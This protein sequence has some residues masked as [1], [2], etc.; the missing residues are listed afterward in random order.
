MSSN[1]TFGV[2]YEFINSISYKS[3]D[4]KIQTSCTPWAI[5]TAVLEFMLANCHTTPRNKNHQLFT[6]PASQPA[7]EPTHLHTRRI[8]E[9]ICFTCQT[10]KKPKITTTPT[11]TMSGTKQTTCLS[12]CPSLGCKRFKQQCHDH[13][14]SYPLAWYACPYVCVWANVLP[15]GRLWCRINNLDKLPSKEIFIVR[16]KFGCGVLCIAFFS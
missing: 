14:W 13:L 2:P 3:L 9:I 15:G 10:C 16:H 4:R 7:N 1:K 11:K 8:K 12:V 6:R 5:N